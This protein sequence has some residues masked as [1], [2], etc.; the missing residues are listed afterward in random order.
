MPSSLQVALHNH[1]TTDQLWGAY[2]TGI[3][4]QE[5][6]GQRCLLLP[7]GHSLYFP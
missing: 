4:L 7:D 3:S 1:S 2:I 6:Q 5:N